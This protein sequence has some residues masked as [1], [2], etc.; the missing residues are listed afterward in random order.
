MDST[1][2]DSGVDEY[3]GV[4][5]SEVVAVATTSAPKA[6]KYE[7]HFCHTHNS[8]CKGT[9]KTAHTQ[10][11]EQKNEVNRILFYIEGTIMTLGAR[12]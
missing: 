7:V 9:T 3:A 1:R 8:A 5:G 2:R 12:T 10:I 6:T 11:F 4:L